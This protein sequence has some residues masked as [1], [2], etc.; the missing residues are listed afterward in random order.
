LLHVSEVSETRIRS[1]E[2]VLSVGQTI[3]V[4]VKEK[5]GEGRLRFSAKEKKSEAH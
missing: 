3:K 2:D 5:D 4:W 1:L